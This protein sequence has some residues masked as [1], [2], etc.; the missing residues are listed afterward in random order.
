MDLNSVMGPPLQRCLEKVLPIRS[1][2]K[3][4]G[5]TIQTLCAQ[6][7]ARLP[8]P[9]GGIFSGC[10]A[11]KRRAADPQGKCR[12]GGPVDLSPSGGPGG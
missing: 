8:V 1:R 9:K 2:V 4:V 12:S 6:G 3:A 10:D 5:L 7:E 11:E